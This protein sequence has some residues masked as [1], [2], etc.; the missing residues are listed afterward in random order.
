[1]INI[2]GDLVRRA[3]AGVTSTMSSTVSSVASV[4][5]GGSRRKG[6]DQHGRRSDMGDDDRGLLANAKEKLTITIKV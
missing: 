5:G 3:A 4:A 1:M 2:G 6:A